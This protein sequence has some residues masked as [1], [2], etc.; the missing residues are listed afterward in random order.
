[1]QTGFVYTLSKS[2]TFEAS[3]RLPRHGGKCSRLHG[4]SWKATVEVGADELQADGFQA[5]M[6]VDF[7]IVGNVLKTLVEEKLDHW[8]LN[9]TTGLA[10]P[11]SENLA[12]WIYD[13]LKPIYQQLGVTLA[14]V[15]VDETC[16]SRVRYQP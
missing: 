14:A 11:T 2:A 6:A 13:N 7:Y 12:R 8:H 3:H 1:M 15:T 5:G 4:H 16:T 10:D 9:D